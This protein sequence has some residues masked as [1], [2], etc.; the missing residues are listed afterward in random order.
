MSKDI[1]KQ[2]EEILLAEYAIGD[3]AEEEAVNGCVK[4]ILEVVTKAQT[5]AELKVWT[6]I[7]GTPVRKMRIL[8]LD[9]DE[10]GNTYDIEYHYNPPKKYV[11]EKVSELNKGVDK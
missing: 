1:S 11:D 6:Y 5:E 4:Q 9:E 8:N 10:T 3:G 7:S 2:I